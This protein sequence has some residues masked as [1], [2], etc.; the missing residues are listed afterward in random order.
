MRIYRFLVLAAVA[1]LVVALVAAGAEARQI[2]GRTKSYCQ[3]LVATAVGTDGSCIK[4]PVNV[5]RVVQTPAGPKY[6]GSY[7]LEVPEGQE[8]AVVF[9]KLKANGSLKP[10]T[11]AQFATDATGAR[12]T[13][14]LNVTAPLAGGAAAINLGVTKVMGSRVATASLN[15]LEDVDEDGDGLSDF[16]DPDDDNDAVADDQDAD[17]DG[18][19]VADADED[20]DAD[21]DGLPNIVDPDDDN[22]GVPDRQ[23]LDADGDGALD[24]DGDSDHDGDGVPDAI[25]PDMDNDGLANAQDNDEDGDGIPD[26]YEVDADN[27]G[28]PDDCDNDDDNDGVLD[29]QDEDNDNDGVLD[30]AEQDTDGDGLPDDVDQ[31]DDGDGIPDYQDQASLQLDGG[32]I[33]FALA[34][35]LYSFT[36]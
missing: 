14:R 26:I 25:D 15:P 6:I 27:D 33:V 34:G 16:D 18:D 29:S 21:D 11:E 36:V 23:D 12:K 17:S 7:S 10:K 20:L 2:T 22:D 4:A 1:L 31:D 35:R 9:N 19:G 24:W 28:V 5:N 8:V 32:R 13:C 3:N 30:V